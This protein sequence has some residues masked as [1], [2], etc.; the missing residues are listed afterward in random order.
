MNILV[1]SQCGKNA[2]K[3][4]RRIMDQFAERKG[5]RVWQTQITME[6][7][8]TLR[9]L[10]KQKARKNTAVVCHWIRGKN[11]S[12]VI[13][14]VGNRSKFN[15][16]GTVPT[17]TTGRD[18]LRRSDEYSWPVQNLI[19]YA[20]SIAGLFHDFG[21]ANTLFQDKLKAAVK[22]KKHKSY[23]P[24]RHEWLSLLF[25][26]FLQAGKTD[27]EWLVLLCEP[28]SNLD[29]LFTDFLENLTFTLKN[30]FLIKEFKGSSEFAQLIAWLILTHHKLPHAPDKIPSLDIL[31]KLGTNRWL[32]RD[33]KAEWNSP[34]VTNNDWTDKEQLK[35]KDFKSGTPFSSSTWQAK[36]KSIANKVLRDY[37]LLPLDQCSSPFVMHVSRMT[38]VMADHLYSGALPVKAW[39]DSEYK[40]YANTDKNTGLKQKLDEHNIGVAHNAFLMSKRLSQARDLMPSVSDIT[41]LKKR[42][43]NPRFKWQDQAYD[44]ARSL[45]QK[46]AEQGFF[47]VNMAST[48]KGKTFA[49]AKI[50]YGLS[51]Q[52]KSCRFNVALGLRTL[53]L[54]TGDAFKEKL[55]LYEEDM[56]VL[57]GS[58][59]VRRLHEFNTKE[60]QETSPE[61]AKSFGSESAELLIED[62]TYLAYD[63]MLDETLFGSWLHQSSERVNHVHKLASAP[64]MVSTIDYLMPATENPSGS[65]SIGA[66]LRLLTSDLILDEPDDFGLEDLPALCRLVNWAG[67]MGSRVLLSSATL[68]PSLVQALYEAYS[69]G[70]QGYEKATFGVVKGRVPCAWFDEFGSVDAAC[71]SSDDFKINHTTF[72]LKRIQQLYKKGGTQKK[73]QIL[74]VSGLLNADDLP[75]MLAEQIQEESIRLHTHHH[76]THPDTQTQVSTG[77]IR[78][79]NINAMVEVAR[80]LIQMEAPQDYEIHYCVFHSQFPLLIRSEIEKTLDRMLQRHDEKAFWQNHLVQKAVKQQSNKKHLFIVLGTAVTEVGRD[81]DY[82]WAIVEPSSMRSIIQLA[83]R[84]L[85]H[86]SKEIQAPNISIL[87]HNIKALKGADICYEKPG[88]ESASFQLTSKDMAELLRGEEFQTISS[89]PRLKVEEQLTP[90]QKLVDLEHAHTHAVLFGGGQNSKPA[91]LWWQTSLDWCISYQRATPFRQSMP[92]TEYAWRKEDEFDDLQFYSYSKDQ[93]KWLIQDH[94]FNR[95]EVK[96]AKGI[97]FWPQL[98]IDELIEERSTQL[99]L[100]YEAF[101]SRFLT[102]TL[103]RDEDKWVFNPILGVFRE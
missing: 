103:R 83:G 44:L 13:W 9:R 92:Q 93:T 39:Q 33:F 72:I 94:L 43:S 14:F 86:R 58:Q 19:T 95:V 32:Y 54:Q 24:V 79:A 48:G 71:Q 47:G 23:E 80:A 69:S 17:N 51:N 96:A 21:K 60:S 77:L 29:Q 63:G 56:A 90:Q 97:S 62:D 78:F 42:A 25:F 81:H 30:P 68:P 31:N 11:N 101:S 55:K 46:T 75:V 88:F 6:G 82:D 15:K 45:S 1:I 91:S 67:L 52:Q 98:E 37:T 8:N 22:G 35:V 61:K 12:E 40:A 18:I 76:S 49:N 59:S 7:L 99:N 3:E 5:D 41:A 64:V 102:L 38:L 36:A 70:R 4:T 53:T 57:V 27:Q 87:S 26:L 10:L 28:P 65:K 2:L 74:D 89:I 85:R 16:Q 84:V 100:D 73:G 20:S 34:Q 50:M 66:T